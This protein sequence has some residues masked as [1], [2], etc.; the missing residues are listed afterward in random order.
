MV[1]IN[2][3]IIIFIF[4]SIF[5]VSFFT[6]KMIL[7]NFSKLLSVNAVPAA[8]TQLKNE[9]EMKAVWVSYMDLNMKNTDYSKKAFKEKFN[10]IIKNCKRLK[11]NSLVV[12]VRPF[13]DA[14][15]PSKYFPWSHIVSKEQGQN[16]GYDPLKYMVEK[17]HKDGM[18]FHAWINPFR[19]QLNNIPKKI[20]SSSPFTN[21]KTIKS[22]I[23][24][25]YFV[26]F[27]N[28]K[29]LNPANSKVRELIVS[30]VK[31]I[32]ENYNVDGIHFDDYFYPEVEK[33]SE[34]FDEESYEEYIKNLKKEDNALTHK[35]WRMENVNELIKKVYKEIKSVNPKVVFGI[36]P[37][38]NINANEKI[39]ADV[40]T[41]CQ[42]RGYVDYL[43][44]QI[45]FSLDHPILPFK[46]CADS[47]LSLQKDPSI[48]LYCGLG[49]YKASREDYD[50]GTWKKQA[51]ILK[52][53]VEYT[54][55]KFQGYML[56]DY[57]SLVSEE[58]KTEVENLLKIF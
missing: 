23:L 3:K 30:G 49:A 56:F 11:I 43:C 27:G 22:K 12:H 38:G 7:K 1:K 42:N 15:Y 37:C 29:Y 16:P 46:V 57:G 45:Y 14:L 51:N 17:A 21:F 34:T 4:L 13:S 10:S 39:G 40:K 28:S 55:G 31:E 25:E 35:V 2:K 52:T 33:G 41:W 5:L 50:K 20:G 36:S 18:Q 19:I 44:P 48:K 54:R 8:N 6:F 32:V 9:N 26:D 58:C 47:W 24:N 53:Q